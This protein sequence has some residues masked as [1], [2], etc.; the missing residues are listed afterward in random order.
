MS[1]TGCFGKL[2]SPTAW[3]NLHKFATYLAA[4]WFLLLTSPVAFTLNPW[5]ICYV[6]AIVAPITLG[7]L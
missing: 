1:S 6:S 2:T 4:G 5:T 7:V 3:K